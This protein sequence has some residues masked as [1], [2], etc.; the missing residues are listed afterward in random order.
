MPEA[1]SRYYQTT[2]GKI[3]TYYDGGGQ[4]LVEINAGR[5][6]AGDWGT[7]TKI[8]RRFANGWEAGAYA[9]LT[10]VPFDVFG[11]GSFDKGIYLNVPL[12]WMT[13]TPQMSVR[14]YTIRPITRDGGARLASARQL[15]RLITGAKDAK[16]KRELARL[17]K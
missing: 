2:I 10:D 17:W 9:T 5:Y 7:T 12:D 13:G 14:N 11:E 8:S 16:I 6:L 3:S 4:F 15:Y 1:L